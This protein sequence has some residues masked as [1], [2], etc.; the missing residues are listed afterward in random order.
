VGRVTVDLYEYDA[1]AW[2]GEGRPLESSGDVGDLGP[3]PGHCQLLADA[4]Q[5]GRNGLAAVDEPGGESRVG[6][7]PLGG[8]ELGAS[9]A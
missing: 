3:Q 4:T 1:A 5:A 7:V 8:V 9:A 6:G 2:V